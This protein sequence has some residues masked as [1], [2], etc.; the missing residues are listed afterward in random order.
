MAMYEVEVTRISAVSKSFVV[1]A[2]SLEDA[3]C[4]AE[5]EAKGEYFDHSEGHITYE[6]DA[7]LIH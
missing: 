2:S 1:E 6:C 5:E 3:E 7:E 4:K